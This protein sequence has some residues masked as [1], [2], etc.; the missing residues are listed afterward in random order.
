[1]NSH[2]RRVFLREW[3]K[4]HQAEIEAVL[5]FLQRPKRYE[6]SYVRSDGTL[7]MKEVLF[8]AFSTIK[9]ARDWRKYLQEHGI[10]DSIV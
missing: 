5:A 2:D 6:L 7:E 10:L 8:P 3:R 9:S 1:M 4:T